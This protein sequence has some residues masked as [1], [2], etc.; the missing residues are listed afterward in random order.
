MGMEDLLAE[1]QQ[2]TALG[3]W[4]WDTVTGHVVW[5]SELY[6]IFDLDP[7]VYQPSLEGYSLRLHPDDRLRVNEAIQKALR[8]QSFFDHDERIVRSDGT[9]R[10]LHSR[11]RVI[12]EELSGAVRMVGTCQDVTEVRKLE[13][14]REELL[15]R[16][17]QLRRESEEARRS[18]VRI[19]GRVSDAFVSLDSDWRYTYVNA[20]AGELLGRKPEE[21]IGKHIWTEFPEAVGQKFYDAYH[22]AMNDQVP[23]EIEEFYP[24][25]ERWF[26]N[27]IFPSSDG[28][29]IFFQDVTRIHQAQAALKESEQ[30]F[31]EIAES[32]RE[33]FW[34][35]TADRSRLLY[36]S[37]AFGLVFAI[38][39][40]ATE[41]DS[42]VA[43]IHPEDRDRFLLDYRKETD[44]ASLGGIC[45]I[46]PPDGAVRWVQW[47]ASPVRGSSGEILRFAG[48][49]QDITDLM[50]SQEAL[51]RTQAQ[52]AEALSLTRDRVVQLEEQV[53]SRSSLEQMVGKSV[54]MQEVYRKIRLAAQS[55]VTVLLTGES[56]TGK[57]LAAAA[58]HSLSARRGKPFVAVNCS[59]I[60]EA[61]LESE[62]FGHVKGA[63]TGAV[64]DKEGLFQAANGGTLFLDEA[65][66]ISPQL[67]VKVLR[68]LQEREVR[69]VGDARV[70]KVDVR[71]VA[72]TNRNLEALVAEEK[73]REDFYYRIRVFEI[74]LPPLRDRREDVPLLADH[75]I[76]QISQRMRRTAPGLSPEAMRLLLDHDWPGN[77]RELQNVLEHA[78]VTTPKGIIGPD[79]LPR[80]LRKSEPGGAP[81]TPE[82][83]AERERIV[84]ALRKAGWNRTKAAENL[85]TSRVN[86]WKKIRRYGIVDPPTKDR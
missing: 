27:R 7:N 83:Q 18:I 53:R 37:P 4:E 19:L 65:G 72:A 62:L 39:P 33:A 49:A 21:L 85:G 78:L 17:R 64:R 43:S 16:E 45:R 32:I 30:R 73:I 71:I 55:D 41:L 81:L 11:G 5:S 56:G 47:R 48:S 14:D 59:A 23:A 25:W 26:V 40:A 68:A 3:S 35:A 52:L 82:Q 80:L 77:V 86:L 50:E 20:R 1:S 2:L 58:V 67:Q 42:W 13:A 84:A 10:V 28:L 6:R 46:L 63:F 60:P 15:S 69:R 75:L 54:H 74:T 61:L 44:A 29:S 36:A 51:R 79:H 31:R 12:R 57:E 70:Q 38:P 22:R 66:D 34:V 8:E 24:P 9:V 76:G